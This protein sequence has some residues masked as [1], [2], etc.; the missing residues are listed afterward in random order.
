MTYYS[1]RCDSIGSLITKHI[2]TICKKFE[3]RKQDIGVCK[4]I[5][6]DES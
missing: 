4:C 3:T 5:I 1:I 6:K 2:P